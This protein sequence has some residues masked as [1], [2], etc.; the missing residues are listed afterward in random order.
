M[1]TKRSIKI[2]NPKKEK[3]NIGGLI[4]ET[5]KHQGESKE[6]L[7]YKYDKSTEGKTKKT[8]S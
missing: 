4:T 2:K 1:Q 6:L 5:F 8:I 3:C 7:I